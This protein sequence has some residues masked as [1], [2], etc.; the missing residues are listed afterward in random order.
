MEENYN[1]KEINREE[2]NKGIFTSFKLNRYLGNIYNYYRSDICLNENNLIF[3]GKKED[4]NNYEENFNKINDNNE[5]N[6][7][8]LQINYKN[9]D[10][11]KRKTKKTNR[12]IKLSSLL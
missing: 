4:I 11:N 12:T 9:R 3:K 8:S 6:S 5:N 2:N 7:V 1:I 10:L